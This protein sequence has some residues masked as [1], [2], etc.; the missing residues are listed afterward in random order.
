MLSYD[1]N[2]SDGKWKTSKSKDLL[3]DRQ[4][5]RHTHTHRPPYRVSQF[6]PVAD[7]L[8]L[9]W[10][11][12]LL[13]IG[14]RAFPVAAASVWNNLPDDVTSSSFLPTF[15]CHLKTHLFCRRYNTV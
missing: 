15:R 14:N 7:I 12:R 2:L 5:D 6:T 8:R 9:S 13:T 11:F 3:S 10:T 4:T 1:E